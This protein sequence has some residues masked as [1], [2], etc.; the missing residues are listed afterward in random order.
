MLRREKNQIRDMDE[1]IKIKSKKDVKISREPTSFMPLG[2][3][4]VGNKMVDFHLALF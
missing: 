1:I 3:G 2:K 4:K